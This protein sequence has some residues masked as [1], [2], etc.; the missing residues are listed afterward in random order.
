MC[1]QIDNG[2]NIYYNFGKD[3]MKIPGTCLVSV[4]LRLEEF[5]TGPYIGEA[6]NTW[7]NARVKKSLLK[8]AIFVL[9][10]AMTLL[11]ILNLKV[12]WDLTH[13]NFK[14]SSEALFEQT[15]SLV[16]SNAEDIHEVRTQFSEDCLNRARA[17]AYVLQACP[18]LEEDLAKLQEFAETLDVD[19]IH[20]FN[21]E[22]EIYFGTHPEYYHYTFFSGE[23]MAFFQPM[24]EDHSMELCQEITPNTAEGKLMQYAAVWS[25]DG[26]MIVQIGMEPVRVREVM[27]GR[28]LAAIFNSIPTE[29]GSELYAIDAESGRVV[30][31]TGKWPAGK[32]AED[33]GVDLKQKTGTVSLTHIPID[34]MRCCAAIYRSDTLILVRTVLS[35]QLY[36]QLGLNTVFLALNVFLISL[37]AVVAAL[38]FIDRRIVQKLADINQVLREIGKGQLEQ[39]P[40]SA[41][42]PELEELCGYI[43]QMLMRVRESSLK[44]SIALE[45]SKLPIGIFEYPTEFQQGFATSR[46]R[47]ILLLEGTCR[48]QQEN[49]KQIT[50]CIS[51][52]KEKGGLTENNIYELNSPDGLRFIRLDEMDYKKSH[53]V[54]LVDVTADW[55]QQEQLRYQ[56]DQDDLTGLYN[57]RGFYAQMELLMQNV[58]HLGLG[59]MIMLD[60]DGLKTI[61]DTYG[62]AQGDLYLIKISEIL[63]GFPK[64]HIIS[65]RLG[66]DEFAAFFYGYGS[67]EL[68]DKTLMALKESDEK[69]TLRVEDCGQELQ[70]RYSIGWARFPGD[71]VDYHALLHL[72]DQRMYENKRQ[73][74]RET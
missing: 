27:E 39:L 12:Q 66:G 35:R 50:D 73:R 32:Q 33:L 29:K 52:L 61:N 22:G 42:L 7:G 47:D 11:L 53:M 59:A 71:S 72:A 16:Q 14:A 6:E 51:A 70:V 23:Q 3:Y 49:L 64:N 43:N 37:V 74:K 15:E 36:Q 65:A 45:K 4:K 30:A 8:V 28:T 5:C 25:E 24:L 10:L 38:L 21:T 34:G 17:A 60:A 58:S 57:R 56:R 13:Q 41:A 31:S 40:S 62:H 44:T 20:L 26:S 9:L 63:K 55:R 46:V 48:D 1:V 2:R 19:E 68:L 67:K 54:I 18:E 69:H